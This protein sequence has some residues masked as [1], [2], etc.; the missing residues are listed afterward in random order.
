MRIS[1]ANYI[2][3]DILE[4]IRNPDD[5]K[6]YVKA[7]YPKMEFVGEGCTRVVVRER[8]K[9]CV[10]KISVGRDVSSNK[11]EYTLFKG[12]QDHP[13]QE[14]FCPCTYITPCGT[15]LVQEY[16]PIKMPSYTYHNM[17][18]VEKFILESFKFLEKVAGEKGIILDMHPDNLRLTRDY[19]I[20]MIDY[21]TALSPLCSV[22]TFDMGE[23]IKKIQRMRKGS[24][25]VMYIDSMKGFA[26]RGEHKVVTMYQGYGHE[27]II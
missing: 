7:S 25:V 22:K 9:R 18:P 24:P 16:M 13:L 2:A 8:N 6:R 1:L 20:K 14:L 11:A 4:N 15:V 23:C 3:S 5:L 12:L 19:D 27:E 10:Y 17:Q 26:A 21:A